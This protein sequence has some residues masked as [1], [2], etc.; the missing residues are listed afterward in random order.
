MGPAGAG[1]GAGSPEGT[2]R[3]YPMAFGCV[4]RYQTS[5]A[6]SPTPKSVPNTIETTEGGRMGGWKR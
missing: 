5:H 1:A 4:T 2:S 3:W 6:I